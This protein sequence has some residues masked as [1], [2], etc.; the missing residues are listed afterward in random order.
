MRGRPRKEIA[1][2]HKRSYRSLGALAPSSPRFLSAGNKFESGGVKIGNAF[3]CGQLSPKPIRKPVVS[4]LPNLILDCQPD[5]T[6]VVWQQNRLAEARCELTPR[7]QKL[8]LYV[9]S[10]IEPEDEFFKLH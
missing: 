4:K 10:M 3:K 1:V 7:V 8:V 9:I 2:I 6:A 5:R